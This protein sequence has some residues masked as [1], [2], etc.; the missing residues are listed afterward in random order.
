MQAMTTEDAWPVHI[1]SS[2][3][4]ALAANRPVVALE[5][6]IFSNLGLPSPSNKEAL[7]RVLVALGRHQAV[8]ALTAVLSGVATVGVEPEL[9]GRICG[10]AAKV[11]ARDLGVAV[12]RKFDYGATTVSATLA[13]ASL[14]GI[15]VFATGGIGG[16][17]RGSELTGDVSADLGA[18]ANHQVITVTAGAKVFL[19]LARTVEYLETVSVPV[20][21]YRTD[22]F[23][24]FHARSSGIE[25][26]VRADSA[27]E[28]AKLA[29]AH[30]A[31]GG[32]GIVVACPIPV[33]HAIDSAVVQDAVD[34]A[35]ALVEARYG[36][37][38]LRG[39]AV[40][41]A[42]LDQLATVT[43]GESV[44]ANL[45]LAEN[46]ASIAGEIAAALANC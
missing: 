38:A 2:V 12:A 20:V 14:A 46:N 27:V 39:P 37:V 5:S 7:D 26:S 32:G 42:I 10:L 33:E 28:V 40:T 23:P 36:T 44:T 29:R 19:D 18:I 15:E 16:V 43:D 45:A 30:W 13:L 41:P 6:T 34:R 11:A 25:L 22:H 24:A 31:L 9:H 3:R 35:L 8:P 1:A 21:G 4:D 17:H